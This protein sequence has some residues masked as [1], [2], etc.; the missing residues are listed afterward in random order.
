MYFFGFP[1]ASM[2][3]E[4]TRSARKGV[5]IPQVFRGSLKDIALARICLSVLFF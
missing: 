3:N 2:T 4:G 5:K 1:I